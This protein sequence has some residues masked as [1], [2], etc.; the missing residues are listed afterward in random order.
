MSLTMPENAQLTAPTM[1][2]F[3]MCFIILHIWQDFEFAAN[4]KYASL[5]NI[6]PYSYNITI[7]ITTTV[8][9]PEFLSTW[10]VHSDAPQQ[11]I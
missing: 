7:I 11:T 4:I 9:L 1:P 6:L 3:S 5:L 10:F 8:I 2:G